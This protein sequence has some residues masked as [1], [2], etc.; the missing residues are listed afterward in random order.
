MFDCGNEER[1]IQIFV[2]ALAAGF[3]CEETG[4]AGGGVQGAATAAGWVFGA[5]GVAG[6]QLSCFQGLDDVALQC[7][8]A[9]QADEPAEGAFTIWGRGVDEHAGHG[10]A[11]LC[12]RAGVEA[13]ADAGGGIAAFQ[14]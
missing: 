9:S 11:F 14:G 3:G 1:A 7:F 6:A 12:G 4:V 13:L 8:G 2:A 5:K 10:T